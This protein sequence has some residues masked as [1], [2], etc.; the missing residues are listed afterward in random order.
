MMLIYSLR[1]V[2]KEFFRYGTP[3][4]MDANLYTNIA[5]WRYVADVLFIFILFALVN[6]I[7]GNLYYYY[8]LH[9]FM[10]YFI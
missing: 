8:L 9:L 5:D 1:D 7:K 6:I 4:N 10:K 2:F 3:Y